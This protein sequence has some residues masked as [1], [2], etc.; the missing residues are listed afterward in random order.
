MRKMKSFKPLCVLAITCMVMVAGCGGTSSNAQPTSSA[1]SGDD[2]GKKAPEEKVTIHLLSRNAG[3]D[4]MLPVWEE[5]KKRFQALHP[6]VTFQDD[7]V[8]EEAAYFNKLKTAIATGN[9]PNFFYYP[10][11]AGLVGYA[12]NGVIMDISPML[13]DKKWADGFI[14]GALNTWD[15]EKFGVKGLYGIPNGFN[16]EVIFYNPDMFAKAG[17]DKTPETM[18]ELYQVIDKLKAAN[19]IPWG[20]GA[21]DTWRAGHIHNNLIYRTVGVE[22]IKDLGVRKAKWTDPD[23]VRS[24]ELLKDLKTK[25]A[26]EKGFEGIDYNT[27]KNGFFS[28]KYAMDLNGAWMIGDIMA[29]NSPYKDKFKFFPFP[30]LTDKPEYKSNSVLFNEGYMLSGTMKGKEKDL[31][32][33]FAKFVTSQEMQEYKL[34]T[35]ERLTPRKDTKPAD[36][37]SQLFKDMVD[38]MGTIQVP[39]GDYFDY[40]PDPAMIDKSRNAIIGMFLGKTPEQ[41]AKDIQDELDKFE[42]NKK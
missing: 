26:F 32:I 31:T 21:K 15:L 25:G 1:A 27:E 28:G 10:G 34:Q 16:P 36:A 5:T 4:S 24:L 3:S 42:K 23:V 18:E 35:I 11:V 22:K 33:E 40:D 6:N 7:S 41:T 14:D 13:E 30:S 37:A 29:S 12:K 2:G 9:T 19:I 39:G 8:A 17:I 38:Y 20:V